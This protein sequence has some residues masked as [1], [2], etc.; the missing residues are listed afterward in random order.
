MPFRLFFIQ[1]AVVAVATIMSYPQSIH[2]RGALWV[3]SDRQE[4][5]WI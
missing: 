4:N 1:L 3:F 5:R 2:A